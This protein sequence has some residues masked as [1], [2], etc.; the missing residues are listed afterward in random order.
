MCYVFAAHNGSPQFRRNR[1]WYVFKSQQY[2]GKRKCD[3][4]ATHNGSPQYRRNR[5][6][7]VFHN[8]INMVGSES[9]MFRHRTMN[10]H[11]IVGIKTVMFSESQSSA[12]R[13]DTGYHVENRC[14]WHLN[15]SARLSLASGS[16]Q[17]RTGEIQDISL[18]TDASGI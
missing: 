17:I 15:S 8:Y 1:K 2:R 13:S 12:R 3:V 7:Y 5:N 16:K 18:K 9:V 14:A 11:N 6:C 10:H 4:F